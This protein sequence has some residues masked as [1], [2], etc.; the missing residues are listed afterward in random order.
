MTDSPPEALARCGRSPNTSGQAGACPRPAQRALALSSAPLLISTH[1]G[2]T[3]IYH[4]TFRK[5]SP[6]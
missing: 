1:A 5:P 6:P 4:L 2:V 3:N